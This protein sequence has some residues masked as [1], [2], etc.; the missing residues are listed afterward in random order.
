MPWPIISQLVESSVFLWSTFWRNGS[1]CYWKRYKV[2]TCFF[3]MFFNGS[4]HR[5]HSCGRCH[6]T[7]RL[8]DKFL[9]KTI[10]AFLSSPRQMAGW[11]L[12]SGHD[13]FLSDIFLFI[14]YR[15]LHRLTVC[16]WSSVYIS[17]ARSSCMYITRKGPICI[18]DPASQ[19]TPT[20]SYL[21]QPVSNVQENN[22]FPKRRL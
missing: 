4:Q 10:M 17:E 22:C 20:F 21:D 1:S 2:T 12:K 19:K 7:Y 16:Y 14:I 13:R 5:R 6:F 9:T 18:S 15:P 11:Y 3:R 8:L